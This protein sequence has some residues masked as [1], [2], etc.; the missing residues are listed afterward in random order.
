M[1]SCPEKNEGTGWRDS[2]EFILH[3]CMDRVPSDE[4]SVVAVEEI[5]GYFTTN[6]SNSA[7][8]PVE[9]VLHP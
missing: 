4:R 3:S 1:Y 9:S 6:S 5:D 7:V 8:Q 2:I